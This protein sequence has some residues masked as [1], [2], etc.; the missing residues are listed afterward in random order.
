MRWHCDGI[1]SRLYQESPLP[2]LSELLAP[3]CAS[4]DLLENLPVHATLSSN[5]YSR[6]CGEFAILSEVWPSRRHCLQNVIGIWIN[7]HATFV[8]NA[9][10]T[11]AYLDRIRTPAKTIIQTGQVG[12]I[13]LADALMVSWIPSWSH[14]TDLNNLPI[15]VYRTF[16]VW[17]YSVYVIVIPCLTFVATL[18]EFKRFVSKEQIMT[19]SPVSGVSFVKIQHQTNVETS[20]FT[21]SVTQWTVAFLL[22]SFATTVY[23]TGNSMMSTGWM[24]FNLIYSRSYRVQ[25][26]EVPNEPPSAWLGDK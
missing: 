4:E 9:A 7:I 21:K 2:S 3:Y 18:S 26:A 19:I 12:A 17:S 15:K 8:V 23:S 6:D 5:F 22:C 16:V 13:I 14:V 25:V 20:V 24:D 10:D 1:Y 11:E